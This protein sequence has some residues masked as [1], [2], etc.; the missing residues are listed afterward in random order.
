MNFNVYSIFD[1]K[2]KIFSQPFVA[3]NDDVAKR[4]FSVL[5]NDVQT[6]V[7]RHPSDFSLHRLATF[8]DNLGT[9]DD[10]I[11]IENLGLAT[12]YKT[13]AVNV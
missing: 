3:L 5:A 4:N 6:Q 10:E 2:S 9:F 8:D 11:G 12:L 7:G 1:S 13:E